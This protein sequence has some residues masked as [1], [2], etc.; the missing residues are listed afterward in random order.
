MDKF[1]KNPLYQG[2]MIF[3]TLVLVV[4][5]MYDQYKGK[6]TFF[7]LLTPEATKTV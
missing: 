5:V 4:A 1:L 7:G 6:K 3:A 2:V